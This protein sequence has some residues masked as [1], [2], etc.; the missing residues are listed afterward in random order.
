VDAAGSTH[1][2]QPGCVGAS[3]TSH[4]ASSHLRFSI[5]FI[6]KVMIKISLL[7]RVKDFLDVAAIHC[8]RFVL[9]GYL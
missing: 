4:R 1:N 5:V 7:V 9:L 3:A 8:T 2:H 6:K